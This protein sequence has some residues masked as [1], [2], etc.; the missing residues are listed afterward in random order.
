LSTLVFTDMHYSWWPRFS[1]GHAAVF[2]SD[3]HW[4][5]N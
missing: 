4:N 1:E 2:G 3:D 5:S